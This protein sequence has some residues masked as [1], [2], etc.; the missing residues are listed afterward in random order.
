M[1]SP[2]RAGEACPRRNRRRTDGLES[3]GAGG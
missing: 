3:R 1:R 2:E